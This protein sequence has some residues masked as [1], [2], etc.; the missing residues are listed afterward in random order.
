M[1][2]EARTQEKQLL[3]ME[4][5]H[6]LTAGTNSGRKGKIRQKTRGCNEIEK[7]A[8]LEQKQNQ[9]TLRSRGEDKVNGEL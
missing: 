2:R 5:L 9:E 6:G 1:K 3:K 8:Q 7:R 4:L